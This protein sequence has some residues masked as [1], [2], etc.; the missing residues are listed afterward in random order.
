MSYLRT[1]NRCGIDIAVALGVF[2]GVSMLTWRVR[3]RES[4]ADQRHSRPERPEARIM[5]NGTV[6]LLAARV[7]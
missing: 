3:L 6:A 4:F 1:S 5:T 2:L 7:R